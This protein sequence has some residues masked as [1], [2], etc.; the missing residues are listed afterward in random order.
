MKTIGIFYGSTTGTTEEVAGRIAEALGAGSENV[1]DVSQTA[2]SKV[3]EYDVLLFGSS[4]WGDGELQDD[5]HDFLDGVAALDLKGKQV[6]VFGCGDETMSDTFCNAVGLMYGVLRKTGAEMIGAFNADG[7]DFSHSD[8][9]VDGRIV[10]LVIDNV[11]HEDL[12][13]G[14]ISEWTDEIRR[15]I[16]G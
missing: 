10:G 11:N 14:K 2:P 12:T 5:M 13:S 9:E 3:G 16:A 8:S 4:T 7:Y 6:A 15:Q 1:F